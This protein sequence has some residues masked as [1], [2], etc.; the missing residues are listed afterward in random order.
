MRL[1]LPYGDNP[2]RSAELAYRSHYSE[3]TLTKGTELWIGRMARY[4]LEHMHEPQKLGLN[5][6]LKPGKLSSHTWY[7]DRFR[8]VIF[9]SIFPIYDSARDS[10]SYTRMGIPFFR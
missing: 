6:K 9:L 7:K 2:D 4:G 1:C 8:Q 5:Q 3:Y 10:H